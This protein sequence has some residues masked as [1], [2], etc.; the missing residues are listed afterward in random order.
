MTSRIPEAGVRIP[1]DVTRIVVLEGPE[2]K[3]FFSA[4]AEQLGINDQL[5]FITCNG[6]DCLGSTLE[7]ILNDGNFHGIQQIGIICDNDFPDSRDGRGALETVQDE[8]D[9]ANNAIDES[10]KTT[11]KLPRPRKPRETEGTKPKVSVLLL[12][13]DHRDG[14]LENLVLDAIG[15]DN[16]T[17]C[18]DA[19]Y[20]CLESQAQVKLQKAREPRSRLSVYISGKIVDKTYATNDDSRRWFL[21][22][23][24]D[25]K[26]WKD[27]K[28][29][30][31]PQ[32]KPAKA[33]LRQLLKP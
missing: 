27:E 14:M 32:F 26:W 15:E 28:M 2:D 11:R 12:P 23:A 6:K 30:D 4:L 29:W 9:E 24:V 10:L 22:Q 20:A 18:V 33:F 7:N 31:K 21:T 25:M 17:N 13:D 5:H 1:A 8:I 3:T 19:Y 16:I